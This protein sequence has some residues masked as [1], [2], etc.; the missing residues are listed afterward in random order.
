MPG[1]AATTYG[2]A[3]TQWLAVTTTPGLRISPS[4]MV[5]GC[6]PLNVSFTSGSPLIST[7]KRSPSGPK[8][9]AGSKCSSPMNQLTLAVTTG[10]PSTS[11]RQWNF[12]A[13][14]WP[15]SMTPTGAS[16]GC[17]GDGD[18]LHRLELGIDVEPHL[19]HDHPHRRLEARAQQADDRSGH[20]LLGRH[21]EAH[22]VAHDVGRVV[23]ADVAELLRPHVR[24]RG[25][26]RRHH[27][28]EPL[29]DA[30]GVNA[31][32]V[33]RA[34]ALGA[35]VEDGLAV[36]EIGVDPPDRRDH[37]LARPKERDHLVLVRQQRAVDH[38][39]GVEGEDVV[40]A[41]RRGD[42]DR[43]EADELADVLAVLARPS[44]PTRR[45]A[46]GRGA[47]APPRSPPCPRRRSPTAPLESS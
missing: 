35:G 26:Q 45:P 7:S 46:R 20:R 2:I 5:S 36:V 21:A 37:V 12:R 44:A 14:T 47:P 25:S 27:E 34:A 42:A 23:G 29:G 4:S 15:G 30:T 6:R 39:V 19:R 17:G 22:D 43:V 40:H 24:H 8:L 38:A 1:S 41:G 9:H 3:L 28:R 16:I 11:A 33:Q 10:V 13:A 32:A 31:G 18:L